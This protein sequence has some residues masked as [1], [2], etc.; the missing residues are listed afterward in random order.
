MIPLTSPEIQDI[1]EAVSK[2]TVRELLLSLGVDAS[3]PREILELQKDFAYV[4]VWRQSIDTAKSK[5]LG[6]AVFFLVTA[7]LG[8]LGWAFTAFVRGN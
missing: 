1:A 8:F 7:F 2:R 6:A 4:R 3:E 5:G